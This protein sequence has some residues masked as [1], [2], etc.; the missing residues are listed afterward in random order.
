MKKIIYGISFALGLTGVTAQDFVNTEVEKR[1][2]VLEKFTGINCAACPA[3]DVEIELLSNQLGEQFIAF[4][5]HTFGDPL[6]GQDDYGT[7]HGP[8][9]AG[10]AMAT[11]YPAANINRIS[12]PEFAQNE[13]GTAISKS[14]WAAAIDEMKEED[15]YVNVGAKLEYDT[16]HNSVTVKVEVYYTGTPS[17][18]DR[19]HVAVIQNHIIGFQAGGS[20]DYEHNHMVRKMLTGEG[21]EELNGEAQIG[22][23]IELEY[24]WELPV[25]IR[26][27]D[28]LPEDLEVVAFIT[29]DEGEVNNGIIADPEFVVNYVV[30]PAAK[31]KDNTFCTNTISPKFDLTNY[32]DQTINNLDITYSING[33]Q[34]TY[35]WEG[36]LETFDIEEV[37]LPEVTFMPIGENNL[38]IEILNPNQNFNGFDEGMAN[39]III[40][41]FDDAE[42]YHSFIH[43]KLKLDGFVNETRWELINSDGEALYEG[44]PYQYGSIDLVEAV[45]ELEDDECYQ[46]R[47]LDED[48]NGLVGGQNEETGTTFPSGFY[49]LFVNGDNVL[50][51]S[52]FGSLKEH[53]FSI[54]MATVSLEE[55]EANDI[56]V[57]P[58]PAKDDLFV[59]F[60]I[61]QSTA[62]EIS[63]TNQLGQKVYGKVVD[64]ELGQNK[65][66][67]P[68]SNLTAGFYFVKIQM[69]DTTRIKKVVIE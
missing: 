10:A 45:F 14:D 20:D 43:F 44:G 58:N 64:T 60:G 49:Q 6:E 23:F 19:I 50:E 63:L 31:I 37:V 3:G 13:D 29:D 2:V 33:I 11:G 18:E 25:D 9:I 27:I 7:E 34:Y 8:N 51:G 61:D 38:T 65:F 21:G 39:N 24:T 62:V 56:L 15:A 30:N 5:H 32:G 1:H 42:Y 67:I 48:G 69:G 40:E 66:S 41:N 28:L 16:E 59:S 17:D 36:D 54:D 4:A 47:I 68:V 57:Y 53:T 26:A 22:S 12:F 35:A 52:D 46:L 55:L